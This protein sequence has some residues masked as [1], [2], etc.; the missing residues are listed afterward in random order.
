MKDITFDEDYDIL[1]EMIT[2]TEEAYKETLR[3]ERKDRN[4]L[5]DELIKLYEDRNQMCEEYEQASV[6][7]EGK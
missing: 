5:L 2:A 3:G 1:Q 4:Q 7:K 6:K